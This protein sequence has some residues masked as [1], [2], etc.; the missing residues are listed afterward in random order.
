MLDVLDHD[1]V[2]ELRMNNPPVNALRP[3]LMTAVDKAIQDAPGDG[4]RALCLSGAPGMFSAGLD[5]P[6][7]LSSD[8]NGPA[9]LES[10]FELVRTIAGSP[11]PI[12]AGITGHSPAGGAVMALFCDHRVMAE[13]DFRIG[14]N[15][16]EVGLPVPPVVH[17]ALT[18]L[19]GENRAADLCMRGALLDPRQALEIG[20]V[21][22]VVD[23]EQV[24]ETAI[25]WCQ[26]LLARPPE[27]VRITRT[28]ARA[29]LVE[30][31]AAL[32]EENRRTM[33]DAWSSDETQ[34]AMQALMGR[35]AAKKAGAK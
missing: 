19:V 29:G 9:S 8:D 26:S 15:E 2:R 13:G 7:M 16:V 21:D 11:I 20:F 1:A 6:Y 31:V 25:A 32:W 23:A 17:H 28:Q 33:L 14:L 5:V 12:A 24:V 30:A 10:L 3:S 35:L 27:A 34:D 22:Q 18:R 4:C